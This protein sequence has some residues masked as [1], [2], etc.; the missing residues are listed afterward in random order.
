MAIVPKIESK[1]RMNLT[2]IVLDVVNEHLGVPFDLVELLRRGLH[3]R[4]HF[5]VITT[6]KLSQRLRETIQESVDNACPAM[7][8]VEI[9][10]E[11]GKIQ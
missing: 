11:T 7:P 4:Y 9:E 6:R 2:S 1:I 8:G 3:D 10:F 5:K